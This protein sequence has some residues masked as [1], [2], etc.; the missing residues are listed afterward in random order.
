MEDMRIHS[1]VTQKTKAINHFE[2][3]DVDKRALLRGILKELGKMM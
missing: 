1:N 3:P 2:Q